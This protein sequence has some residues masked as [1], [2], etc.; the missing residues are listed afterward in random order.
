MSIGVVVLSR[1]SSARLPGKALMKVGEK[2]ILDIIFER[3]TRVVSLADIVIATS[4]ELSDAPIA[5]FANRTGVACYRGS[6]DN[7]ATRFY[8]AAFSQ[9]WSYAVRINGDNIFLDTDVL[10]KMIGIAQRGDYDFVSNVKGRTFP[11]GMSVEIVKLRYFE[12]LLP[13]INASQSYMEHVT[14]CLYEKGHGNHYYYMNDEMPEASGIQMALDTWDDLVRTKAIMDRFRGDHW[15][16][17]MKEIFE[18]WMS[19]KNEGRI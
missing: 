8:E 10:R 16:Y 1:F 11:K 2:T 15:T 7:V 4:D 17:N 13:V 14:L 3:L 9:G 6:I 18:I 12:L 5:D 19:L